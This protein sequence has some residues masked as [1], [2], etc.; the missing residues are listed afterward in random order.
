M[1]TDAVHV[2]PTNSRPSHL[3]ETSSDRKYWL[4]RFEPLKYR[5]ASR[6]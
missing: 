6:E 5:N 1:A 2:L 3:P 4:A